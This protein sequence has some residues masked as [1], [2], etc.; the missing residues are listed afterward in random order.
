MARGFKEIH[1]MREI[2]WLKRVKVNIGIL[3]LLKQVILFFIKIEVRKVLVQRIDSLKVEPIQLEDQ[4][5][6][7]AL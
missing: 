5:L 7:I 3:S 2:S 4:I 1:M 6:M